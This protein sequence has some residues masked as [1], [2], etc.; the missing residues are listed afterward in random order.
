[1][2]GGGLHQTLHRS[3]F[4]TQTCQEPQPQGSAAEKEGL[5]NIYIYLKQKGIIHL[6]L[7]VQRYTYVTI[8]TSR[9]D[10]YHDTYR[11]NTILL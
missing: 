3:Q 10:M 9:Y 6:G 4:F 8:L 2:P 5:C 11:I 1:M 7:G